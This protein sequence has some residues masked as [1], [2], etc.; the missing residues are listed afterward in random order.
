MK[1]LI[2]YL[3][4]EMGFTTLPNTCESKVVN[5]DVSISEDEDHLYV[6]APV[7]G[8]KPDQ[9]QLTFEKGILWVK[10][11]A[12]E[13]NKGEKYL[14]KANSTFS[15]RVPLPIRVDEQS[16]P[17]ASCKDG[18]LKVTFPKSRASRPLKITINE[19]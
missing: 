7:P 2:P 4:D 10:A 15:Y 17:Q 18:L 13:E 9:I 11:E 14:F 8:V 19:G 12:A 5:S 3:L 6:K 1:T 16:P